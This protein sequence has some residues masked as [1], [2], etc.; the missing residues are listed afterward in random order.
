MENKNCIA[1]L[2][3]KSGA[4]DNKIPKNFSKSALSKAEILQANSNSHGGFDLDL[5][6]SNKPSW[7]C[8]DYQRFI[9]KLTGTRFSNNWRPYPLS[10]NIPKVLKEIYCVIE[11][12]L[13][14]FQF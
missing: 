10:D 1:K 7:L 14:L 2:L 12:L 5:T 6:S 4:Q 11:S 9:K 3:A 8:T 13:S